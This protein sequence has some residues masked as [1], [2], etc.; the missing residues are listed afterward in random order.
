MTAKTLL[1]KDLAADDFDPQWNEKL[2]LDQ[3]FLD[4][5]TAAAAAEQAMEAEKK[6]A[7]EHGMATDDSQACPP[8]TNTVKRKRKPRGTNKSAATKS[9]THHRQQQHRQTPATE[10]IYKLE[11]YW[12]D[13][14]DTD[15]H[16]IA[17]PYIPAG[18]LD[19]NLV[20]VIFI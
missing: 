9:K 19:N 1:D 13:A 4:L 6:S 15:T 8:P 3:S 2:E 14:M 10:E 7:K 12:A 18:T 20:N 5:C 16:F 11:P 17:D